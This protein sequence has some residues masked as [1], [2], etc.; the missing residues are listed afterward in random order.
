MMTKS[1]RRADTDCHN[2]SFTSKGFILAQAILA[3]AVPAQ[4]VSASRHIQEWVVGATRVAQYR[5][6]IFCCLFLTI[7]FYLLLI[8]LNKSSEFLVILYSRLAHPLPSEGK[9]GQVYTSGTYKF[10]GKESRPLSPFSELPCAKPLLPSVKSI[11]RW[12]RRARG[13]RRVCQVVLWVVSRRL[14][15]RLARLFEMRFQ[16]SLVWRLLRLSAVVLVV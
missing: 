16:R 3:Q 2:R 11:C 13:S 15:R 1:G 12:G 7:Y 6:K 9:Y 14:V 8:T 5:Q 10:F 4:A